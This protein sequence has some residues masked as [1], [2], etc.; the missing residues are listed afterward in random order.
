MNTILPINSPRRTFN[1][2]IDAI[3]S[4][5]IFLFVYT[6]ISKLITFEEFKS[7]MRNQTFPAWM[8]TGLIWTLPA[9]ELITSVFLLVPRW[10]TAGFWISFLLL[11]LFTGY[12]LLVLTNYFGRVPCSCGG[13]IKALGW[14]SHLAVNTIFLLLSLFGIYLKNRERRIVGTV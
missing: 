5:L 12:I 14:K 2:M 6:A 9:S 7:Q 1:N 13:V 4:L 11:T 8:A 10:R 3:A